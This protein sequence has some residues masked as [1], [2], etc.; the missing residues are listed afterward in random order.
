MGSKI[1]IGVVGVGHLGKHHAK[2]FS[3]MP[4]VELIGVYDVDRRRCREVANEN[5]T[6]PFE[7]LDALLETVEAVSVVTPTEHHK[8]VAE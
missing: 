4:N 6:T 3:N 7:S 5:M 8:S 1:K 2:H